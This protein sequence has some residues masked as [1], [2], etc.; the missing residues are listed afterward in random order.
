M[1]QHC[2][3]VSL[4][5][6]L[7]S[8]TLSLLSLF[9]S[10]LPLFCDV[11]KCSP[12]TSSAQVLLPHGVLP[13]LPSLCPSPTSWQHRLA[14][15]LGLGWKLPWP[16]RLSHQTGIQVHVASV[17]S[18]FAFFFFFL[19]LTRTFH[20]SYPHAPS[21]VIY[22]LSPVLICPQ[23]KLHLWGLQPRLHSCHC[24]NIFI[25]KPFSVSLLDF[26]WPRQSW[27][28]KTRILF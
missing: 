24:R 19:L 1:K 8:K 3:F 7:M 25:S 27:T 16:W 26:R 20:K 5:F 11:G 4:L 17:P 21:E 23:P 13:Y 2:H 9:S 6:L 12:K 14:A 10:S 15:Q 22:L 28:I 18:S